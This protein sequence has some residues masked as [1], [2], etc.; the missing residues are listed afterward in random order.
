MVRSLKVWSFLIL[1]ILIAACPGATG[2]RI[3]VDPQELID[4]NIKGES[5]YRLTALLFITTYRAVFR[6]QV[7]PAYVD[8]HMKYAKEDKLWKKQKDFAVNFVFMDQD[9]GKVNLYL[10]QQWPDIPLR[11]TL[12]NELKA[13]QH[14][15]VPMY[16]VLF[17]DEKGQVK[18]RLVPLAR[19]NLDYLKPHIERM[20]SKTPLQ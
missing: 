18:M 14:Y 19:D 2:S 11:V 13:T 16:E 9:P 15:E 6:D 7:I 8:L 1:V 10:D 12:D 4:F 5:P 17:I 3:I 20:L